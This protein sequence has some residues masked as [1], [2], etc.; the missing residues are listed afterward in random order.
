LLPS[1][2]PTE[3]LKELPDIL[4]GAGGSAGFVDRAFYVLYYKCKQDAC[5][6]SVPRQ[7]LETVTAVTR[8]DL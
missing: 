8:L 1:S 2:V 7:S 6:I 4:T 5:C 3:H